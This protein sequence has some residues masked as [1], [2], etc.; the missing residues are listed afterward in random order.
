MIFE[1]KFMVFDG[2]SM[3]NMI[4]TWEL[5]FSRVFD[6]GYFGPNRETSI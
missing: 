5:I 1:I 2:E 6:E 3:K 4:G